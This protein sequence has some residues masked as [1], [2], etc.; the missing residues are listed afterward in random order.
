VTSLGADPRSD[1]PER[2]RREAAFAHGLAR[3][4]LR[5]HGLAH[6]VAQDALLAAL[7]QRGE[8]PHSLRGW[9]AAVVR[10]LAGRTRDAERDRRD[11]EHGAARPEAG[12]DEQRTQEQIAVHRR[13]CD[14]LAAL[15]EPYRTAVALRFLDGLPPRAIA[16]RLGRDAAAVR[17]HVHR[18]L[19][20]LRQRLDR[21]FGDRSGWVGA[22]AACGLGRPSSIA[23]FAPVM[24]MKKL[25]L[26]AVVLLAAGIW[27]FAR[28]HG[29][30]A[31]S[32]PA[33]RADVAAQPSTARADGSAPATL[34]A[35]DAGAAPQRVAIGFAVHV[36]D[37]AAAPV[38]G[39]TV[40]CFR[41]RGEGVVAT[42]DGRGAASF[43]ADEGPGA[44]IVD[45]PARLRRIEVVPR[46][47]GDLEVRLASGAEVSG[48][49]LVDGAPAPAGLVLTLTSQSGPRPEGLP[50]AANAWLE[51]NSS[52]WQ[53]RATTDDDGRFA[54]V[55]LAADWSGNLRAPSTH[56]LIPEWMVPDST[57]PAFQ[58][59][60][61]MFLP[62]P[63]TGLLLATTRLPTV[64]G[65]VVWADDG[66][67]V[68]APRVWVH[69]LVDEEVEDGSF[70]VSG[71]ASGDDA[72]RFA[73]GL[74]P[75]GSGRCA[76]WAEP[77]LRHP[78]TKIG[79]MAVAPGSRPTDGVREGDDWVVRLPREPVS[80]FLAVDEHERPIAGARVEVH[81]GELSAPT[82]RDGRGTFAGTRECVGA[83]GFQVM[84]ASPRT[85]AA[86]TA[87]DPLVF[88]LVPQNEL[89]LHL[90]TPTGGVPGTRHLQLR[91]AT[92]P[93]HGGRIQG[94]LD[95]VF[96]SST[97]FSIGTTSSIEADVRGDVVLRSL[98]PGL[99]GTFAACDVQ[100]HDVAAIEVVTPASGE[101]LEVTLVVSDQPRRIAGHVLAGDGTPLRAAHV[102]LWIGKATLSTQTY[103]VDRDGA[104]AIPD[105][106]GDDDVHVVALCPGYATA[107]RTGLGR[108]QDGVPIEFRLQPAHRVTA[109]VLDADDHPV[110]LFVRADAG[111]T[112]RPDH[113]YLGPGEFRFDDLPAGTVT[114]SCMLGDQRFA[115]EHDTSRDTAVLRV[116][117]PA[118]VTLTTSAAAL[119]AAWLIVLATR[120]PA[121]TA[122]L[123][124]AVT[125]GRAGPTLLPPGRYR[126]AL[127]QA[128]RG[129]GDA[130]TRTPIGSATEVELRAGATTA[131]VLQ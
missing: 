48:R 58:N 30:P 1:W 77:K 111:R 80:H 104:F 40:R 84:P 98:T 26:A 128:Q 53:A 16:R 15:P 64:S 27:W 55:G 36:V 92:A 85:A 6:D 39:A 11:R 113:Q 54:F 57:L 32:A 56:W 70:Q 89:V 93:F 50:A 52:P 33:G 118:S 74:E 14:A 38:R 120:L 42:T 108:A 122:P 100:R 41:D 101:R 130:V 114:F 23:P 60:T 20:L 105:L 37:D 17:L 75:N 86:G 49:V 25:V 45:A 121:A 96:G 88:V 119:P 59:P 22:F 78:I 67:P 102:E 116:P 61:R 87:D 18:G 66:T 8:A 79:C 99:H 43:A 103:R 47:V 126:F 91:T 31:V 51:T 10:R 13:L 110:A 107:E 95:R 3:A 24:L 72:G 62:Q 106:H 124:L 19:L 81:S 127:V 94:T 46:M 21:E 4:L 68:P 97:A 117:V 28:D 71:N 65:R 12:D 73:I 69:G 83:P 129:D 123:E 131:V 82:G 63:Q 9:L 125:S 35:G 7:Q 5:D 34:P 29:T 115:I 2:L 90:R 76:L 44:V 109:R 112:E